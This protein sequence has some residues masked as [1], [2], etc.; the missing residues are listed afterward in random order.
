M[1]VPASATLEKKQ[2][3]NARRTLAKLLSTDLDFHQAASNYAS[4]ALHA[5]AAKF[6][7]QL[8][9]VFIEGLTEKGE[10]VMDPMMGSGTAIVEAFLCGRR[11]VGFDID[12]LALLICRVKTH[13][14][15]LLE[16]T[17]GGQRIVSS[18]VKLLHRAS[19]LEASMKERFSPASMEFIDYWFSKQTQR[20]LM[21]LL[22]A[23][24]HE[25]LPKQLEDFIKVVFSSI[26]ITKSGGVSL[27]YDLAHT[28]PH[29][30]ENKPYKDTIT[31]FEQRLAKSAAL[32]SQLP[33]NGKNVEIQRRDSRGPL[34]L[35]DD[36]I[37]LIVTSPPYAN[38]IDYMR[39]HKFSLVWFGEDI[40][41]LSTLRSTYIGSEKAGG[42]ELLELPGSVCR[43]V[44]RLKAVD[45]TKSRVLAKYFDD[46]R[47][48]L[49]EMFRVLEP[50]RC[51]IVVVG[52]ST[53]RGQTIK[54][55]ELLADTGK[56]IGFD[57]VDIA[58]RKLD[59]N[60]RMLP[61]AFRRNH[62]SQI[63]SRM[64]EEYIIGF[65]KPAT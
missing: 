1:N 18:T 4:H 51:C 41:S 59:R 40:R 52:P 9:R 27:A 47:L 6:P 61:M 65:F 50:G 11:A 58:Q 16:A 33:S 32:M 22:L 64:H 39:A 44:E 56:Q 63:E 36:S 13:R 19:R 23:I 17:W 48:A 35:K 37:Q 26:I 38:A 30:L 8:P 34:P 20:E 2:Q 24:E 5:F 3:T 53:M 57:T 21:A 15:D 14:V 7:P 12:P 43:V 62:N 49:C 10:T 31:V 60:R 55:H 42:L 46:M 25:N 28:R 54:T 29:R 45:D